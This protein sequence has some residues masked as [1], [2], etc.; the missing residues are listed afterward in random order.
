MNKLNKNDVETVSS[1]MSGA[2]RTKFLASVMVVNDSVQQGEWIP[3]GSVKA[4]SGFYQGLYSKVDRDLPHALYMTLRFG[5]P[6]AGDTSTLSTLERSWVNLCNQMVGISRELDTARP[7]PKQTAIGLSPK[8]TKTLLECNLDL[9]LSSIKPA[10]IGFRDIQD[11]NQDGTLKFNHAGEP[12]MVR[13][14][15]P[16]WSPGILHN[17]SRFC[18]GCQACG[19]HIPSGRF[20]PVEAHCKRLNAKVS[21]WLGQD[22]AANIFGIKDVGLDRTEGTK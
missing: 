18:G 14:Y 5:R 9:D 16:V 4:T 10:E 8:V 7:K 20:V 11:R 12:V 19:K 1:R 15:F 21:L 22:C 6:Y 13:F 3:R 2:R 17:Q